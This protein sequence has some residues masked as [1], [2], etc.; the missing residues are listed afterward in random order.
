MDVGSSRFGLV[1][2]AA[3]VTVKITS[4]SSTGFLRAAIQTGK[5]R[6]VQSGNWMYV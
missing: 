6:D 4:V 1:L 5:I 2:R 3:K